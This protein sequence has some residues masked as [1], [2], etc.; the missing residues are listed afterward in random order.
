[1]STVGEPSSCRPTSWIWSS[2]CATT[3]PSS[4]PA[5]WSPPVR[6]T[7][8]APAP[9]S[10]TASSRSSAGAASERGRSGCDTRKAAPAGPSE[11]VPPQHRSAGRG[12]HR[13]SVR[14][15]RAAR[16]AGGPGRPVLRA[17]R[18]GD[19]RGRAGRVGRRAGLGGVPA[20]A[21]RCRADARSRPPRRVPDRAPPPDDGD[22]AQR[23]RRGRG[24]GDHDRIA[25][26]RPP[27]AAFPRDRANRPG[28]RR[29]R[30]GDLHRHLARSDLDRQRSG[31]GPAVP[32]GERAAHP[33]PAHP[34]RADH[35]RLSS[36]LRSS[37]DAL[38]AVAAGLGWSPLGAVW[39]VPGAFAAGDAG[40]ALLRLLIAL[41]TFAVLWAVWRWGLARSLV[42]PVHAA[43]RVRAPG[44]SGL[45]GVFPG[46]AAGAI[47]ARCLTYWFRDPRYLRQLLVIPLLPAVM[48][49]YASINGPLGY[50]LAAGPVVAFSLGIGM[51]ADVSYDSTA[52]A[53]HVSKAVPG[54][55]DRWGRATALLSFAL[56]ATV[57]I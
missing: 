38:P 3:S 37:A 15:L 25:R 22:A 35:H 24:R 39:A 17:R 41:A 8:C 9:R 47:A 11:L 34:G 14:R 51:I 26:D 42:T 20:S 21:V 49:F 30:G 44:K 46:T 40:G 28:D 4:P 32:R 1:M 13:R 10:K 52:F 6:W 43:S 33:D 50:L 53:L 5:V 48:W 36:G 27:V 7:R 2:G 29:A 45:F 16:G 12:H 18:G 57:I 31:V 54:R 55:A 23:G 56:P 19:D